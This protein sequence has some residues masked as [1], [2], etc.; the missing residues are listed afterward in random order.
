MV[1][2]PMSE[3]IN[4]PPKMPSDE[5]L[6]QLADLLVVPSEQR[7]FFFEFVC[8][9]VQTAWELDGLAKQGLASKK[10]KK[11]V[12]AALT[13]YDT[14]GNLTHREREL[15]KGIFSKAAFIFDRIS[16][17]GVPG[18]EKTAHQLALLASL[19]TGKPSP[20]YPSQLPESPGQGRRLGSIK[21]TIFQQFVWDLLISITEA[22]GTFTYE[23]QTPR[24][25]L[26]EAINKLAPSLPD[27]FVPKPLPGL[28]RLIDSHSRVASGVDELEDELERDSSDDLL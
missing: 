7:E 20:R 6:Q 15:I 23:K 17:G 8:T 18:L 2:G 21:N 19:I 25:T 26:V 4:T 13:L 16:S 27:Q 11:F 24:G 1:C 3:V 14:I 9:N 28:Q 10:G 22:G 5:V 12:A